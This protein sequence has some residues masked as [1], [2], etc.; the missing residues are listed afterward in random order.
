MAHLL[1]TFLTLVT[2]A[3]LSAQGVDFNRDVR[4]ILT[5]NCTT[6]HGG[7]KMAGEVSFLYREDVLGKGESGKPVVVPGDPAASEMIRRILTDDPDDR[8]PPPDHHPKPL[9]DADVETLTEWVREGAKWGEHWAFQ[10]PVMPEM[11]D[12]ADSDWPE[13]ELDRFILAKLE[14]ENLKPSPEADGAEWLRRASLDLT[15]LPPTLEEFEAFRKAAAQNPEDAMEQAV[16][17]LLASPAYGEHWA[18]MWLD[19]ARYSDTFGFEKDPHREI[20]PYRDWVIDAF[21]A[22]MPFDQFTIKQLAG[23]LIE[24]PEPRDLIASAFHR[25][26]QNNTEGGTDDEE[27]RTAAVID[28]VNTTWTAWNATTMGCV[29]CHA[30]PYDPIPHEDYY[31]FL[32]FFNNTEDIDRNDDWPKTKVAHNPSQQADVVR[33]EKQIR[34]R[35]EDLNRPLRE[36]ALEVD[37]WQTLSF[38]KTV[39]EP[40]TGKLDQQPDGVV[41]SSGTTPNRGVFV[42]ETEAR[43]LSLIR[44]EIFPEQDDPAEW[45]GKGAVIS[46]FE[47]AYVSPTGGKRPIKFEEVAAD[48]LAG[49]YLPGE[50]LKGGGGGFGEYPAVHQPRTAWF[51]PG[52]S[53]TPQAGERLEIRVRHGATC[54]ESQSCILPRFKIAT[55]GDDRLVRH[56]GS[57]AHQAVRDELAGLEKEYRGIGGTMIPVMLERSEAAKRPT[58]LFI[59]GNR[60]TRGD[61]VEPGVPSVFGGEGI[62]GDRLD[63]AR[64]LVGEKNPL[65]A[66]TLANRLWAQVFGTGIVET[67]EDFGSSGSVPTHP[68]LLDF[69]ALRLRDHHKWHLKPFLREM[70]LSATYRQSNR[71]TP[72]LLEKDPR[73]RLLARGP[74]QRLTAEMVRDQALLVS[75]LLE[76]KLGGKPV[77]PPQPEG[78][79]NSVYS[80]AKWKTS[81]GPDR[82]RRGIYTY[83]KRTAGYPAFLTF[84]ASPRDVCLPRRLT[85]NTPLQAL[86]TLNDPA[87]IEF[88]Q[89][90][91]E[92]MG[93][94]GSDLRIQLAHGYRLITL[95]DATPEELDI[96]ATLHAETKA[97]YE[98]APDESAKLGSNPNEAA[99]VLVANT[100][101]NSDLALNR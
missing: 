81:T 93:G 12:I 59:R 10:A 86:V 41:V 52:E 60:M 56:V 16:D 14:A 44:V 77:F 80:G 24:D 57:P 73:N 34:Q 62:T 17:R 61:E 94:A 2:A 49:P 35:N 46:G 47:A 9:S 72:E 58:R 75:G 69:L 90:L 18:A 5:K 96:L 66:R 7:V 3:S 67:Q 65:A 98:K 68:E 36:A 26:T 82:Y 8:M 83:H 1:P 39:V 43:P 25:N 11:P 51:I 91:A 40:D 23:D 22:D 84:D 55:S 31:R 30:H 19:L 48:F 71:A 101:L 27:Y 79:W 85:T 37:D 21:N 78:V 63:M 70:V 15:G 33:L 100:L 42:L 54:N 29:Q 50:A 4:P 64:W 28:R 76:R 13:Q 99:L 74:R 95:R 87:H 32:A 53:A 45:S 89:G 92:R 97:E 88:A 38:D 6:C 20:W